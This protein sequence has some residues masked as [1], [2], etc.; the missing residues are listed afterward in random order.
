VQRQ[1]HPESDRKLDRGT[2]KD[3]GGGDKE[4]FLAVVALMKAADTWPQFITMIDRALPK[5]KPLPLF[6]PPENQP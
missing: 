6:D 3:A 5:Y 4:R 1:R 2:E